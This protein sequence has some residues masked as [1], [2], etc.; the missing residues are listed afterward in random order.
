MFLRKIIYIVFVS[1]VVLVFGCKNPAGP[2]GGDIPPDEPVN[3]APY[4]ITGPSEVTFVYDF[5][6]VR[7]ILIDTASPGSDL[8]P[9]GDVVTFFSTPVLSE[10]EAVVQDGMSMN[11]ATGVIS[12]LNYG[13][14]KADEIIVV[15]TEDESG[16]K[17]T[18]YS[19]TIH[20]DDG[21]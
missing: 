12:I 2:D 5:G 9:D 21:T 3:Q 17:S 8:D 10:T 14:Y 18:D 16:L 6:A 11:H 4:D 15:W 1:F 7:T 13:N 19:I 20:F